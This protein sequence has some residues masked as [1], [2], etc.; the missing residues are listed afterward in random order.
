MCENCMLMSC[1]YRFENLM[2]VMDD[3]FIKFWFGKDSV[4][5]ECKKYKPDGSD[6]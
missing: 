2:Y 5:I 6:E 1:K 4:E 3:S